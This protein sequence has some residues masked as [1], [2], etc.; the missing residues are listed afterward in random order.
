MDKKLTTAIEGLFLAVL[1]ILVIVCGVGQTVDI[2]FGVVA[3]VA[4]LLLLVFAGL[5]ISKKMPL[6]VG[7]VIMG[8]VL[9]TVA[10]ALFAQK[11][12]FAML[13][14]LMIFLLMGLGFGLAALGV[15][16]ICKKAPVYG[17]GLLVIGALLVTFTALYL[18]INDFR[19]VFWYIVGGLMIAFGV[20]I[21]VLA[22]VDPKKLKKR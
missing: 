16:A 15:F 11:L 17:V 1:G 21:V 7:F 19:Q 14:D 8:S 5:A 6:P 2:Y 3:I 10:I 4:G 12:S 18:G 22:F 9:I 13:V 20:V